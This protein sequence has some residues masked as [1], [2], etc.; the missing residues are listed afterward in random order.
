VK[1]AE[2]WPPNTPVP[3]P[4]E[5]ARLAASLPSYKND[6]Q[7]AIEQAV[8]L[9]RACAAETSKIQSIHDILTSPVTA[10]LQLIAQLASSGR[11]VPPEEDFPLSVKAFCDQVG[12]TAS[13]NYRKQYLTDAIENSGIY[14]DENLSHE[15]IYER[16]KRDKIKSP[17]Q[18][19]RILTSYLLAH[20]GSD[21]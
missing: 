10:D 18:F 19:A 6:T 8:S 12:V 4:F 13:N 17:I 16:I 3:T 1:P 15:E 5:V 20:P 14:A 9:L 2:S 7:A 21:A 11:P